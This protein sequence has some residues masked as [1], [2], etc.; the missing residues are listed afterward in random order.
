MRRVKRCHR[1]MVRYHH[2]GSVPASLA[3]SLTRFVNV[4]PPP[5]ATTAAAVY[6]GDDDTD[7]GPEKHDQHQPKRCGAE[8]AEWESVSCC[9][10]CA[11]RLRVVVG[12]VADV[13]MGIVDR[14]RDQCDGFVLW[15]TL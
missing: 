8:E 5:T 7:D 9:W 14:V 2:V 1:L 15:S 6:V 12:V 11:R 13:A 4:V 10:R 3:R